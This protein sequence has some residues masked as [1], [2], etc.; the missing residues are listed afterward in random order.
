MIPI[1]SFE[2]WLDNRVVTELR[3]STHEEDLTYLGYDKMIMSE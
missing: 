3:F 1:C 2:S